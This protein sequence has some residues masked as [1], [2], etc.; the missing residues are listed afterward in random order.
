MIA[1]ADPG[2]HNGLTSAP[3]TLPLG[4]E[5]PLNAGLWGLLHVTLGDLTCV[6]G[7]LLSWQPF[8]LV[9]FDFTWR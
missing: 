8:V 7:L 9:S 5:V 4:R 6:R 3:E 1:G 2:S